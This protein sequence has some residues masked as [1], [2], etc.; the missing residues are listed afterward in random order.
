MRVAASAG[1]IELLPVYAETPAAYPRAFT[2]MRTAG[3]Q[4]LAIVATPEFNRDAEILAALATDAG[5]PT[6][7]EWG[8]MAARGCMLGYGPVPPELW[9]RAGHYV[10]RILQGAAPSDLPID[11][12]ARFEFVVN[13]RTAK[14]LAV[15][16][17]TSV[18]SA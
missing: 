16:I 12:P 10:L 7:C 9:Q 4:A 2:S 11:G 18:P 13:A 14:Q 1:G 5:L 8:Q 6:M 17:P 15:A 3:A